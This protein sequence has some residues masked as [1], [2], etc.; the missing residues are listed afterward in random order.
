[1]N[2]YGKEIEVIFRHRL[3][4][5]QKFTGVKELVRQMKSDRENACNLL[6]R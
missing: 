6:K 4:D 3:R 5:E 2:I 1:M